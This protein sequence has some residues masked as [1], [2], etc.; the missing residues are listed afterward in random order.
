[1]AEPGKALKEACGPCDVAAAHSV[2]EICKLDRQKAAQFADVL[3]CP[4]RRCRVELRVRSVNVCA[5]LNEILDDCPVS[6]KR[7][8]V[9]RSCANRILLV[10]KVGMV[11]KD[12]ADLLKLAV[13]R[14]FDEVLQVGHKSGRQQS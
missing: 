5:L 3:D 2:R 14:G 1:V 12:G 6:A 10:D 13:D 8:V 11:L 4:S 9:Q 7:C